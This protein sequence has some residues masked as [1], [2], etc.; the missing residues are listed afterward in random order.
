MTM[1]VSELASKMGLKVKDAIEVLKTSGVSVKNGSSEIPDSLGNSLLATHQQI[2]DA[3]GLPPQLPSAKEVQSGK[4]ELP[5]PEEVGHLAIADAQTIAES[6]DASI[7]VIYTMM[8]RIQQRYDELLVKQG[9][10]K[11]QRDEALVNQGR[12]VYHLAVQQDRLTKLEQANQELDAQSVNSVLGS[13]GID[14][15]SLTERAQSAVDNYTAN[16]QQRVDS[17][18]HFI[19]TGKLLT[20]DDGNEVKPDFFTLTMHQLQIPA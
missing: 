10:Q 1:K 4:A 8:D 5:E 3:V 11:A 17:A 9:I 16:E 18:K 19:Q 20:D 12:A 14:I 15:T 2:T 6:N 13:M 7:T